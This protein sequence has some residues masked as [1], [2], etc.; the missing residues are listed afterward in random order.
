MTRLLS[1][2]FTGSGTCQSMQLK[3]LPGVQPDPGM[4]STQLAA[5]KTAGVDVYVSMGAG[6]IGGSTASKVLISTANGGKVDDVYAGI[7]FGSDLQVAYFNALATVDTKVP[8]TEDGMDAIKK[9][10]R[11]V[12]QQYVRNG[13]LAPGAWNGA[14]DFGDHDDLIRNVTD[15][16][17]Y[18]Y[19]SPVALQDE[20]DRIAG[21][22]PL[23]QIAGKEAGAVLGGNVLVNLNQ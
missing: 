4:D 22:A 9:A 14:D 19:T 10:M 8:Q 20:S 18:I 13:F 17:F 15:V 7:A 11:G 23:A 16:G 21:N 12:C 1:V 3:T 6:G 5:C 2:D